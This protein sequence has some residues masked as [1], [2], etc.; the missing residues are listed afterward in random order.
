MHSEL[1]A[2]IDELEAIEPDALSDAELHEL[3]VALQQ[4]ESRLGAVRSRLLGA[5]DLRRIWAD[6]GSKTAS[7]RLSR[8]CELSPRT[9]RCEMARARKLRTMPAT[10]EALREGK[11]SIDQADL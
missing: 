5:W 4:E 6:D 2:A 3:V 8:E 1:G 11:L 9:A 10:A 7:A